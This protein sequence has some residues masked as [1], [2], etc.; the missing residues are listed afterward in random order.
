MYL[1]DIKEIEKL[2]ASNLPYSIERIA[3]ILRTSLKIYPDIKD[4]FLRG[5]PEEKTRAKKL[6]ALI[7]M[8]IDEE[9]KKAQ[10][11]LDVR[12]STFDTSLA[13]YLSGREMSLYKEATDFVRKNREDFL[14]KIVPA[15]RRRAK[16]AVLRC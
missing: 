15:S 12:K 14:P 10:E 8:R 2:L 13:S 16:K 6:A 1:I 4:A 3:E 9:M 7:L 5:N 11:A